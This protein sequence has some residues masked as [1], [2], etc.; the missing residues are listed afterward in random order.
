LPRPMGTSFPTV[1]PYRVFRASDRGIAIAV[2]SEKLW[3]AFC[4]VIGRPDLSSHPD[5]ESNAA[6]IRNRDVLEQLIDS[7][8]ME[9]PAAEWIERLRAAGIPCSLVRNFREVAD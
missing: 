5:Y 8:F 9:R 3:V 1:V 6:R 2:G 7:V 4:A